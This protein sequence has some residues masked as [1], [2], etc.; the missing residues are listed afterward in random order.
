MEIGTIDL[1]SFFVILDEIQPGQAPQ[2]TI[3]VPTGKNAIAGGMWPN[4]RIPYIISSVFSTTITHS[5][6]LILATKFYV[7][8]SYTLD[9]NQ[10]QIIANAMNE[11]MKNTCITFVERTNEADY[12]VIDDGSG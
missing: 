5:I 1:L 8:L 2:C 11:Y 6:L 10:R 4:N 9:T 7:R 12:I 3:L